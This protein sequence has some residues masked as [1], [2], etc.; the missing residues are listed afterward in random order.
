MKKIVIIVLAA[1]FILVLIGAFMYLTPKVPDIIIPNET[2]RKLR[3]ED[4]PGVTDVRKFSDVNKLKSNRSITKNIRPANI[5]P[6]NTPKP[7]P[8]PRIEINYSIEQTSS[9]RSFSAGSGNVFVIVTIDIRNYG[10]KYFDAFPSKFKYGEIEPLVNVTTGNDLDAVIPN[11]SRTE[12][13][14][15]FLLD[16][17]RAYVRKIAYSS[18]DYRI[19]YKKT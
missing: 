6:A 7:L 2:T 13:N 10:Y 1:V 14:L 8:Y 12:G 19:L 3:F 9:I 17:K 18:N 16:K 5:R 11:S 15:V 4:I